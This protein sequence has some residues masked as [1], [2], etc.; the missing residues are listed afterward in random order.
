[1]HEQYIDRTGTAIAIRPY[2][3]ED[4]DA[5]CAVHD[6]SR[7]DELCGSCDP[8]AFVPLAEDQEYLEDVRRSHKLVAC[9][10]ERVVA[11]VGVDGTYLSWLYVDPAYYGRGIGRRLL[12][13]GKQQIGPEAWTISL[14]NNQRALRLYASEG[15][16]IVQTF[17]GDNAGYPC[18]GVKLAFKG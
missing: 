9:D 7:P 12:Q 6:R 11:F 15:F 18:E 17:Q 2:R 4:W 14:A 16:A 1:M 13:L 8:R 5:I 10:G 3:D